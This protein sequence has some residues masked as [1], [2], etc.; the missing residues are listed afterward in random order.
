[1][2]YFRHYNI[3]CHILLVGISALFLACEST[4]PQISSYQ[5]DL[6]DCL[7]SL[8]TE[9]SCA[10]LITQDIPQGSVG[11]WVIESTSTTNSS[12]FLMT[13][14]E[15]ELNLSDTVVFPWQ[16]QDQINMSLYFFSQSITQATCNNL[17]YNNECDSSDDCVLRMDRA[18]VNLSPDQT[19]GFR[20][21]SGQ[22]S[23][24]NVLSESPERCDGQDNDCDGQVDESIAYV[25]ATC[26]EEVGTCIRLGELVCND[27]NES[28]QVNDD[29]STEVC[30]GQDNDCDGKSDEDFAVGQ[31]CIETSEEECN[32]KRGTYQC[33]AQG[34]L[35]CEIDEDQSIE[36]VPEVCDGLDN[37]CNGIID[38]IQSD[39]LGQNC[40]QEVDQTC[41]YSA[42]KCIAMDLM[43]TDDEE[44][45]SEEIIDPTLIEAQRLNLSC[46]ILYEKIP[47]ELCG[48]RD[49]ND[50]DGLIDEG[51]QDV[52]VPCF[53][54]VG[55]C[56]G[57]GTYE[58]SDDLE[59][60]MCAV[61]NRMLPI[62]ELC[63]DEIDNDCD[64]ST[65]EGFNLG[66]ICEAN[67]I[68][69]LLGRTS[70]DDQE[71]VCKS[72][73]DPSSDP[74]LCD[75]QDNDCDGL[76][77][78]GIIPADTCRQGIGVCQRVGFY[79]CDEIGGIKCSAIATPPGVELCGDNLDNDCD[80]R[81][82]EGFQVEGVQCNKGGCARTDGVTVCSENRLDSLCVF[83]DIV[84]DCNSIDDDCDGLFDEDFISQSIDCPPNS[85]SAV[86]F[87]Q[88]IN[89]IE[90]VS[91]DN[92]CKSQGQLTGNPDDREDRNCDGLDNDC[93]GTIDESYQSTQSTCGLAACYTTGT[94]R[95][96]QGAII[97][98]CTPL[99]PLEEEDQSCNQQDDDCD[100]ALDE[101]YSNTLSCGE[102]ICSTIVALNCI[103][104]EEVGEC[105]PGNGL[106]H[107]L[108]NNG[109]DD[110]C[111]G[112]VDESTLVEGEACIK[113][114]ENGCTLPGIWQCTGDNVPIQCVVNPSDVA[115]IID[116]CDGIDNDCNG[117]IDEGH[118]EIQC[119]LL[120]LDESE[121]CSIGRLLCSEG[122]T[123]C[124]PQ[125]TQDESCN[126]IDDDCDGE[127]DEGDVCADLLANN[128]EL[129]LGWAD[130]NSL[131]TNPPWDTWGACPGNPEDP[132]IHEDTSS[133]ACIST[134]RDQKFHRL[135]F[136]GNVDY[137]DWLGIRWSCSRNEDLSD[138]ENSVLTWA[139]SSCH[140]ALAYT[141]YNRNTLDDLDADEDCTF[142]STTDTRQPRCIKTPSNGQFAGLKLEGNVGSDDRFGFAFWCD[143]LEDI[144]NSQSTV[145]EIM[146]NLSVYLGLYN[147]RGS[148]E[149]RK[150][151]V[152]EDGWG[153]CP[154][155][156]FKTG[157]KTRCTSTQ[158]NRIFRTIKPDSNSDNCDQISVGLI[159]K[160]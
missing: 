125:L 68:C 66:S 31:V 93:D 27:G 3:S 153:S 114:L 111:D 24:Y 87:T 98:E 80:S 147:K 154:E 44:M 6:S 15:S 77:D 38:D 20:D 150:Y 117:I 9:Q 75:Y 107:D 8:Q 57:E 12:H 91:V 121:L 84:D 46:S 63:G 50:C 62:E 124:Q 52:G 108:C 103:N 81:I 70:C 61:P 45:F 128:C 58:C 73:F 142:A 104:G 49:D 148:S 86:V 43:V 72:E 76:I 79:I 21:D 143:P 1:M 155:D 94:T 101:S 129:W 90:D 152:I 69:G 100:G 88:C 127:V 17:S 19:L 158:E 149:C 23:M 106:P 83:P 113:T 60:K 141:D 138:A 105:V 145:E 132:N 64:G 78:E 151:D 30:D 159:K 130:S 53:T 144:P 122:V 56:A 135:N 71:V 22:C 25:N 118:T 140:V 96:E 55:G 97:D 110:D 99:A 4:T 89:G 146:A 35:V 26:E 126:F 33:G 42:W 36:R 92:L 7:G 40:L 133:R 120:E 137:N 16:N 14:N 39:L 116:V 2:S 156:E 54:G 74:E 139:K 48:D 115:Q 32:T 119:N 131:G 82:D 67:V 157:G 28:C 123:E 59:G 13:W 29:V 51:F 5:L 160:P 134:A 109:L 10:S 102:G 37:D 136:Y 18:A 95:C 41:V 112:A 34:Q 47:L 11:C 65:D 85:C